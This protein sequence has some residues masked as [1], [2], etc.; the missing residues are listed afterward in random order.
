MLN[1]RETQ[2]AGK[3]RGKP[4]VEHKKGG[5]EGMMAEWNTGKD[6]RSVWQAEEEPHSGSGFC[7]SEM[8]KRG[9]LYPFHTWEVEM[10]IS[11]QIKLIPLY[12]VSG[13]GEKSEYSRP[14]LR[15]CKKEKCLTGR[16]NS[17]S[18]VHENPYVSQMYVFRSRKEM[19]QCLEYLTLFSL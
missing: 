14:L 12:V 4:E 19:V 2:H 11:H 10:D 17:G 8:R 9:K 3:K 16:M 15:C 1:K 7:G 18:S 13:L 6:K 5:T